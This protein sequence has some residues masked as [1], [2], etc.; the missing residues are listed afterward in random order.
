MQP[1]RGDLECNDVMWNDGISQA[2]LFMG[3]IV[4]MHAEAET[5]GDGFGIRAALVASC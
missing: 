4:C 3:K 1:S 2:F 5:K